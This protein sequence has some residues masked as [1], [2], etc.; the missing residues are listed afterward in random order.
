MRIALFGDHPLSGTG[1]G[2]QNWQLAAH[3][4]DLGHEVAAFPM[5]HPFRPYTY[6][7]DHP[8]GGTFEL[9]IYAGVDAF[10]V[11]RSLALFRP[12][13]LLHNRDAWGLV[14]DIPGT[15]DVRPS[16]A[17][18]REQDGGATCAWILYSP[19]DGP[20]YGP[21]FMATWPTADLC[22]TTTAWGVEVLRRHGYARDNLH[23]FYPGV[24]PVTFT[25]EGDADLVGKPP[26]GWN[27]PGDRPV[28]TFVGTNIAQRKLIALAM[29]AFRS[30]LEHHDPSAY[31]YLH[32]PPTGWFRI[33]QLTAGMGLL[34]YVSSRD[35]AGQSALPWGTTTSAMA[36]LYRGST[37]LLNLST[38]EGFDSPAAEAAACGTPVLVSDTPVR[39]EIRV[40]GGADWNYQL[41]PSKLSFPE[42]YTLGWYC[43]PDQ[44]ADAL[45][46]AIRRGRAKGG[47]P[48][49]LRWANLAKDLERF[50]GMAQDRLPPRPL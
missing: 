2:G 16:I 49:K 36:A 4:I 32:T 15:L 18:H 23:V 13:V 12:H 47:V 17:A 27:L 3:L 14:K 21:D 30:Y 1:Y 25:R 10:A 24:D 48:A 46:A 9:P 6:V 33:D 26:D 39:R 28:I 44:A 41:A 50:C 7:L 19:I 5:Q 43:D 38:R 22:L 37:A 34:G 40:V 8:N 31:L 45:A 42:N 35:V 29:A 20:M 11:R